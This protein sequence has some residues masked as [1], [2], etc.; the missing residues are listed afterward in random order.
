MSGSRCFAT[1]RAPD[2]S[3]RTTTGDSNPGAASK[4]SAPKTPVPRREAEKSSGKA[5]CVPSP[6]CPQADSPRKPQ[7]A[8][9]PGA[10]RGRDPS[11][12]EDGGWSLPCPSDAALRALADPAAPTRAACASSGSRGRSSAS[13]GHRAGRAAERRHRAG[14]GRSARVPAPPSAGTPA[15]AAR[16]QP[17]RAAGTAAGTGDGGLGTHGGRAGAQPRGMAA[18]RAVLRSRCGSDPEPDRGAAQGREEKGRGSDRRCRR[19]APPRRALRDRA[20][21]APSAGDTGTS[22]EGQQTDGREMGKGGRERP[23]MGA[24]RKKEREKGTVKK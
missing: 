12:P 17:C 18:A 10:R 9:K 5:G 6:S 16:G 4:L 7:P 2:Y 20:A 15:G 3:G 8:A 21:A 19:P 24:E 23:G 22:P 1:T 11:K 13:T 14:S